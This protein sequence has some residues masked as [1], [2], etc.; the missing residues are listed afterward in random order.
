M[1]KAYLYAFC[2]LSIAGCGGSS[3]SDGSAGSTGS[4]GTDTDTSSDPTHPTSSASDPTPGCIPGMSIACACT[5]GGMGAQVCNPDGKSLGVCVCDEPATSGG[6]QGMT[7]V[8]P[9]AGTTSGVGG[10]TTG[11]AT[12]GGDSTTGAAESTSGASCDDPGPE[13]NE[14]E[15]EATDQGQQGCMDRP[16]VFTGVLAGDADVDWHTYHGLFGQDCGFGDPLAEHVLTA[17]DD[18]RMCVYADCDD[19]DPEFDCMDAT[20]DTSPNGLPGCCNTGDVTFV[21]NCAMNPN[22]SAQIYVRLDEAP[23]DSCVEYSVQHGY[24]VAN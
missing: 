13:P 12:T 2:W 4:T 3:G 23:A 7:S 14:V 11:D 19:G 10:D 15:D 9:S 20:A 6:T 22:E 18:I 5:G 8:D 17:T 21:L 16:T 24:A 1:T